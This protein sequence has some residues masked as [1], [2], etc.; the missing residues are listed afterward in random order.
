MQ[1]IPSRDWCQRFF[2]VFFTILPPYFLSH[3]FAIVGC[4]AC[5]YLRCFALRYGMSHLS[6]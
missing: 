2:E 6:P 5:M 4:F 3:F 1:A